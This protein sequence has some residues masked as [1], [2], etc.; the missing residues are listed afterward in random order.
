MYFPYKFRSMSQSDKVAT[1]YLMFGAVDDKLLVVT[2]SVMA[3]CE[4]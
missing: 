2:V 3:V 4:A 1:I